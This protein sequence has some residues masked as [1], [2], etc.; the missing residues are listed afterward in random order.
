MLG[1]PIVS[2]GNTEAGAAGCAMTAGV[3]AGLFQDLNEAAAALIREKET[4]LP[5]PAL[6]EA[7]QA[8]YERYRK[9]YEAVRPLM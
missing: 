4:Y 2:L 6:H 5:R 9:L 1:L 8:H 3:A 7:Y